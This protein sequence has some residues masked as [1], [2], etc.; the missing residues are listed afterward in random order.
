MTKDR[1][2][3]I[4]QKKFV[5]AYVAN[6]GN[7]TRAALAA[8]NTVDK[9]TAHQIASETLQK[10]TVK[11]A[12]EKALEKHHITLDAAVKPIA[13]GLV[14]TRASFNTSEEGSKEVADHPTRLK[15]SG[16]AL[17]LL[18]AEQKDQPQGNVF[19]NKAN[20][21]SSKYVED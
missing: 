9:N 10:P 8:Y 17:K 3:T 21:S 1:P 5:K 6:S 14:A 13:D 20:F 19:I 2:L 12:I 15:A 16:M 4:K 7:G 18:G 11:K